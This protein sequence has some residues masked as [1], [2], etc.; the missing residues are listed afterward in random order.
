MKVNSEL[1]SYVGGLIG[2]ADESSE[3]ENCFSRSNL[4]GNLKESWEKGIAAGLV[5]TLK[6]KVINCYY[7]GKSIIKANYEGGLLG[8]THDPSKIENS[9]WD[10]EFSGIGSSKGGEGK[11]TKDMYKETN[12]KDWNFDTIW[13][14]EEGKNYPSLKTPF[15]KQDL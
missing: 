4:Q 9:Y 5:A 1:E 14:I 10:K 11:N 13:K 3:I 2:E 12:Y 15:D 6:G 7:A 8:E